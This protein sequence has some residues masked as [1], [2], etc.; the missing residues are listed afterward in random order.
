M[1]RHDIALFTFSRASFFAGTHKEIF[2]KVPQDN[3]PTKYVH[4]SQ[5]NIAL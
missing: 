4:A 3:I 2:C 1:V 5:G